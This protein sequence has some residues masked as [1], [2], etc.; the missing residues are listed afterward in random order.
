M[1][2]ADEIVRTV[3]DAEVGLD[4]K[5][6]AEALER[7][8]RLERERQDRRAAERRAESRLAERAKWH[9]FGRIVLGCFVAIAIT[10]LSAAIVTSLDCNMC[11]DKAQN[12]LHDCTEQSGADPSAI[13]AC[14]RQ[15]ATT[16]DA[17]EGTP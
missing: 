9:A 13:D 3:Q 14:T 10:A 6:R 7:N 11:R 16:V 8:D 12:F 2:V 17:C 15:F 5:T 1:S 4:A